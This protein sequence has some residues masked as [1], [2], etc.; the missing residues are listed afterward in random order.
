MSKFQIACL[1]CSTV[2]HVPVYSFDEENEE[3]VLMCLNC[4]NKDIVAS[5]KAQVKLRQAKAL[6]TVNP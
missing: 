3:L 6:K 4:G 2:S 5:L 1:D